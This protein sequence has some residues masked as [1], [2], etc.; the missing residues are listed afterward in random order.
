MTLTRPTTTDAAHPNRPPRA[1]RGQ[2]GD[3]RPRK[4]FL[5]W[6]VAVVLLLFT[7]LGAATV[8]LLNSETALHWIIARVQARLP[9]TLTIGAVSGRLR[10]PVLLTDVEYHADTR[11]RIQTITL[12]WRPWALVYG[13]LHLT[14]AQVDDVTIDLGEAREPKPH[15]AWRI[16]IATRIDDGRLRRLHLRRGNNELVTI[17]D[18]VLS[19]R[20]AGSDLDISRLRI[21]APLLSLTAS[22][23][24][25]SDAGIALDWRVRPPGR[26]TWAGN[27]SV[28][29]D[30]RHLRLSQRIEQPLTAT[31]DAELDLSGPKPRFDARV[32]LAHAALRDVDAAWPALTLAGDIQAR[33]A[34]DAFTSNARVRVGRGALRLDT[35]AALERNGNVVTLHKL[36]ARLPDAPGV[37]RATGRYALGASP[38]PLSL[39]LEWRDWRWPGGLPVSPSGTAQLEG[40]TAAYRLEAESAFVAERLPPLH[41]RISARGDAASLTVD[42]LT[43]TTLNGTA[44]G[45]ARLR[46][47][48]WRW[49]VDLRGEGFDPSA[50]WPSVTGR[51]AFNAHVRGDYRARRLRNELAVSAL[52]G[53]LNG[54]TVTASGRWTIEGERHDLRDIVARVGTAQVTAHG[55]VDRTWDVVAQAT[56]PQFGA[57]VPGANGS[58]RARTRASGARHAPIIDGSLTVAGVRHGVYALDAMN[59]TYRLDIGDRERSM[60]E[61]D[62]RK[63]RR[64]ARV[65]ERARLTADGKF[66]AHTLLLHLQTTETEL[67]AELRGAYAAR[68]WAGDITAVAITAAYGQWSLTEPAPV[69]VTP[70]RTRVGLLC[71]QTT[72]AGRAC[73]ELDWPATGPGR[74]ALRAQSLPLAWLNPLLP[75]T[76]RLRGTANANIDARVEQRQA[77]GATA[78]LELARGALYTPDEDRGAIAF[79]GGG[80]RLQL[81]HD[82]LR[83]SAEIALAAGDMVGAELTLPRFRPRAAAGVDQ[84]LAGRLRARLQDLSRLATLSPDLELP[85]GQVDVDFHLGGTLAAPTFRGTAS[86]ADGSANIP[87]LGIRVRKA[88]LRVSGDGGRTLRVDGSV[89]SGAG[90]LAVDGSLALGAAN[91]WDAKLRFRGERVEVA[92]LPQAWVL[93]TPDLTLAARPGWIQL[94]GRIDIPQ[95]TLTP[96]PL[97]TPLPTSRDVVIVNAPEEMERAR[98][99][100]AVETQV[101]VALGDKIMF[102][103]FGLTGRIAG[104]L[105]AV[106]SPERLTTA[107][108]ELRIIDGKY[109][110]YGRKLE[111]ERGRLLFAGGPVDNPGIDARAIRRV[112]DVTAGIAIG[113]T[114]KSPELSLFS[115]PPLSESDT[116]SYL[117]FGRPLESTTGA[118][119]R[120]LASAA[121]ALKLS[122][123]EM[124]AER[125]AARFGIEEVGIESGATSENASL[126][127]GKHLSPR[128]YVNYS[129]GLFEQINVLRLRYQLSTSWALQ[130][131]SGAF[132]GADLL[133]SIER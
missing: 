67:N 132:A 105:V 62:L 89:A 3:N 18:I 75:G 123:G 129:I 72:N 78:E 131:E 4:R 76:L 19:A 26:A 25:D 66:D 56:I 15:N 106:D 41:A 68:T 92:N 49:R 69:S 2:G 107:R 86:L 126:V 57:L 28:R 39:R 124:L 33:G 83:A 111:V 116:L 50:H 70:E 10:G 40:T 21:E 74:A 133:Y 51:L 110:A 87:A 54:R 113:G 8:W 37:M 93:A 95:A 114:L 94:Q 60:I 22:G 99:A 14:V 118:Q 96:K 5:R 82:G 77:V 55:H 112:D 84:P 46:R 101:R 48:P 17:D 88:G 119:G 79:D 47:D 43:L 64:G 31:V 20:A 58:L 23:A 108:G 32:A 9:G 73:G 13:R 81:D 65:I 27:G 63:L 122:G 38:A 117:L 100:W 34:A 120:A 102:D 115:D 6:L 16:P 42:T 121:T 35:D 91:A 59:A 125:L 53:T 80:A 29:G 30:L 130:V 24:L 12:E 36:D 109:E 61:A 127:L 98:R 52:S 97:A 7:V 45:N 128:L 90:E 44:S 85:R 11:V 1:G 71:L 104:G 103:G